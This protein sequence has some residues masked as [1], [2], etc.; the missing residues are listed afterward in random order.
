VLGGGDWAAGVPAEGKG[1]GVV[2]GGV[3]AGSFG[4]WGRMPAPRLGGGGMSGGGVGECGVR[5]V[6]TSR[7]FASLN[8]L[9]WGMA[10]VAGRG[11]G[12]MR[13]GPPVSG[14]GSCVVR[15]LAGGG[16]ALAGS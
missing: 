15:S 9:W 11:G 6:P 8:G 13:V 7:D 5:N 2:S 14:P 4:S 12:L 10:L 3:R 16:S 1:P